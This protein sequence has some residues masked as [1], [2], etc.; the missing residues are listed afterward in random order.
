MEQ[1]RQNNSFKFL[2][3]ILSLIMVVTTISNVFVASGEEGSS[4]TL[5]E[6]FND[7]SSDSKP[8]C[9]FWFPDA[10]AGMNAGADASYGYMVQDL[11]EEM[12]EGGFGGVEITMLAD[13]SSYNN[14]AAK[15]IG[16]GTEAWAETLALALDAAN[17]IEGGFRVDITITSHWPPTTNTI[18]P[19]DDEQQ[20][21]L[22]YTY[23]SVTS[24]DLRDGV[25]LDLP[26][27]KTQD[28]S[29][30]SSLIATFIAQD[31][32]VST[33]LA[34]VDSYDENGEA[35]Y[36]YDSLSSLDYNSLGKADGRGYAAGIPEADANYLV[37]DNT[38][39]T[40]G[41]WRTAT[42]AE[43]NDETISTIEVKNN[44]TFG[45]VPTA[46]YNGSKLDSEG[47]RYRM[48]DWQDMY[49]V[50]LSAEQINS[51]NIDDTAEYVLINVYRRGTGQIMSGGQTIT[52]ANRTY[53]TDYFSTEAV[54]ALLENWDRMLNH[55]YENGGDGT[56]TLRD[57]MK[58][59]QGSIF[60]DS[61]EVHQS[62][63]GL[64][65]ADML[66][67]FEEYIGYDIS[68]YLPIIVGMNINDSSGEASRNK[69]DYNKVL[70]YL[71][72]ERHATTI[73]DYFFEEAGYDYR[74]QAYTLTGLD[75]GGAAMAIDV[76]EG[77]NS[78]T[79]DGI[80]TLASAVN[81]GEKSFLSME[82]LTSAS[83]HATFFEAMQEIN[84]NLSDGIN[85]I[86]LHGI[87][88]SIA[89]SDLNNSS[90]NSWPGWTF[91]SYGVWAP[92]QP[93][94]EDVETFS[95][96][97][98]RIQAVLQAGT[99]KIP[100]AVLKD[101][102][103]VSSFANGNMYQ[104]LLDNG[105]TYNLLTEA[106]LSSDE[107][108]IENG[109]ISPDTAGYQALV[110]HEVEIM[111]VSAMKQVEKFAESGGTI[112]SYNSNPQRVYGTETSTATDEMVQSIY[113]N[114]LNS[115]KIIEISS[116]DELLT[117]L[118]QSDVNTGASYSQSGLE[119]THIEDEADGS[120]YYFFFNECNSDEDNPV[121]NTT[122]NTGT[123]DVADFEAIST[124][125][126]LDGTGA[127]YLL[128]PVS[129]EITPMDYEITS[130]GK[131]KIQLELDAMNTAFV[132]VTESGQFPEHNVPAEKVATG[133]IDLSD[134]QWQLQID[135]W[136]PLDSYDDEIDLTRSK[137]TSLDPIDISI[138][139]YWHEID[140][141][142]DEQLTLAGIS[143]A[144]ALSGIGY[145][146]TE[147]TLP[148]GW[149]SDTMGVIFNYEHK[150]DTTAGGGRWPGSS[151][152]SK[153]VRKTN[154]DAVTSV[155]ITNA[156]GETTTITDINY[157]NE[158]IDLG[159]GFSAGTNTIEVKLV[160]TLKN[161][162]SGSQ[163]H[164]YGLTGAGLTIY[165][166]EDID[167]SD[168]SDPSAAEDP[169]EP[170]NSED[171]SNP[172]EAED[173][174][175]PS[176]SEDPTSSN[177]STSSNADGKT[178]VRTGDIMHFSI[179]VLMIIAGTIMIFTRKRRIK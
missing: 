140:N 126:E 135:S 36:D 39:G 55:V 139:T 66:N 177:D 158:S 127:P 3:V 154:N 119:V 44:S 58:F 138:G 89:Y 168:P 48:A 149:D 9:R 67:E 34:K 174:S 104:S 93:Y 155:T 123:L 90:T 116:E 65:T 47:N 33:V 40:D 173:P 169:S 148:D 30:T 82:A 5:L 142:S 165:R 84:M 42:D 76:P 1:S 52:M 102:S 6:A 78:T 10:G 46:A 59:N 150:Y 61:I 130:E 172:S 170:S 28:F 69:E 144:S 70:S 141:I 18:D 43:V 12:A 63:S 19:N 115:G 145:Y 95:S 56:T 112:I 152:S 137:I 179:A 171:P 32:L 74:A 162:E 85:R 99:S 15:G 22:V 64:W 27:T 133:T 124:E 153:D 37:F 106:V 97:F 134:V 11:I 105:Y 96:Y 146:S 80:R 157:L 21:E 101:Q 13:S 128:D 121:N 159:K 16:W 49:E 51:L 110:L 50:G 117:A 109:A 131:I 72:G 2:A 45:D 94:W 151:S 166:Q 118:G 176:N 23:Q 120:D 91:M 25:L 88:F 129:G 114:L 178:N 164:Y 107:V 156:D 26:E 160:S 132:A 83:N 143:S 57:L 92:R 8:M 68:K 86:I 125:V 122:I 54:N 24:Q 4:R 38:S 167:L 87:P 77:D 111:S 17:N 53:A 60:E 108:T 62:G 35:V 75:I 79:G 73:M 175:D 20:Q 113:S 41:V 136:G 71:Y 7:P 147:V 98:A 100:V 81:I 31:R 161:R 103:T 14:D 29:N 163:Q